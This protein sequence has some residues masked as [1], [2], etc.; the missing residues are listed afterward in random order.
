MKIKYKSL[1][2]T[3][4]NEIVQIKQSIKYEELKLKEQ[5]N[6]LKEQS[7]EQIEIKYQE[8]QLDRDMK[9]EQINDK[10]DLVQIDILSFEQEKEKVI[11][12][13]EEIYSEYEKNLEFVR[14]KFESR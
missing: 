10:I 12:S 6:L 8:F 4:D 3:I 14:E 11:L 2:E 9:I 1:L 7:R 5:I 13:K